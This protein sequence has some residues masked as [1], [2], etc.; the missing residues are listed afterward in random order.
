MVSGWRRASRS[1]NPL[2]LA[3]LVLLF[4]RPMHPYE[5]AATLRVRN[6]GSS[7]KLRYGSLY[8]VI[9]GLH[10]D[11]LIEVKETV[12]E[13]RRPERTI[14]ALTSSGL[15]RMRDWMHELLGTPVKEYPQFEAAL[16]LLPA[17]PLGEAIALLEARLDRLGEMCEELRAAIEVAVK[18]VE[19]LFLVENEFRLSLLEAERQFIEGL[20]PADQ[21]RRGL[22]ADLES[23]PFRADA[24]GRCLTRGGYHERTIV[25]RHHCRRWSGRAL[26]GAG[27][28]KSGS[29]RGGL[30]A[31]PTRAPTGSRATGSTSI[32]RAAGPSIS[33][34]QVDLFASFD[35]TGGA[36]TRGFNI[37]SHRLE[38][39]LHIDLTRVAVTDPIARH[40]S[41][42]RI[43]LRQVLLDGLDD[44]VHFDKKLHSTR[45]RPTAAWS[46]IS[47]TAARRSATSWSGPTAATP[48]S[49]PSSSRMRKR[50]ETGIVG[51]AGK[52]PLNEETR[53]WLPRPILDGIASVSAP[54]GRFM[55]CASMIYPKNGA[56]SRQNRRHRRGRTSCIPACCSTT[57]VTI[58]SGPFRLDAS[59]TRQRPICDAGDGDAL[60]QIVLGMIADWHPQFH[61]L[62]RAADVSTI[63]ALPIRTSVPVPPWPTRNITLLGDAIHSMTPYRGIGA[64]V[65]LRDAA[66]LCRNLAAAHRG[67]TTL[68]EAIRAYESEMLVYGF[69]AVRTSRKAH[70]T[71]PCREPRRQGDRQGCFQDA[72]CD[73]SA[74]AP[75]VSRDQLDGMSA[76]NRF[77][78]SRPA[79]SHP[80]LSC[81]ERIPAT[82]ARDL[83]SGPRAA[84]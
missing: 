78:L 82:I 20:R 37:I 47:T 77:R 17:V 79:R 7:I 76:I 19:A 55:F 45:K 13:G 61:R 11:G 71:C 60:R 58:S 22:C 70:G 48:R 18:H 32:P 34:C 63:A 83:L 40:R 54:K 4:E 23:V 26:P 29:Q 5:I 39:L 44:V 51:I 80:R 73:P 52:V 1:S 57:R 38:E 9:D 35:A 10:E 72:Q 42:S 75:R 8:T 28:E 3:V 66:L 64:N 67:E 49:A 46:R 16:S 30:R 68:L 6:K 56:S 59:C 69:D 25:P 21:G 41:V 62:V 65:A 24:D 12:R 50:V 14:Y 33:V 53:A 81:I 31:R 43:T 2:A 84:L 15:E 74:Q 36:A 27:A